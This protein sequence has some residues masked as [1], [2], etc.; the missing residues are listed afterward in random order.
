MLDYGE[1]MEKVLSRALLI[2]Y[3]LI[4]VWL[5]LF[6]FSFNLSVMHNGTGLNLIPFAA[7]GN[8][9]GGINF[10]E[11]ILN[12]LFFIPLGLLLGVNLK[13][14]E[15]IWKLS[16]VIMFSLT[17]EIIQFIFAMGA[18]DI[19]DVITNTTGGFL[20]LA[21]YELC[22]KF[23]S[24]KKLDRTV[25]TVGVVLFLV[26]G[27]GVVRLAVGRMNDNVAGNTRDVCRRQAATLADQ[28]TDVPGNRDFC[29][30]LNSDTAKP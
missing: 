2:V 1:N 11:I 24:D 14:T 29:A 9:H 21:I 25:I 17:A 3:L 8:M 10:S 18:A 7:S 23:A 30:P 13:K 20:G 28:S 4:L 26:F 22:K 27:A 19:T 6:K 15:F 16:L 5:V 12:C